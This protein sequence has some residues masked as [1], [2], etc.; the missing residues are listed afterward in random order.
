MLTNPPLFEVSY[1][2]IN[3]VGHFLV[4]YGLSGVMVV[5]IPRKWGKYSYFEGGKE[6]IFCRS[7]NIAEIFFVSNSK[8]NVSSV[9][10]HPGSESDCH[11]TILSSDNCLR[12]YDVTNP[13]IPFQVIALSCVE[14]SFYLTSNS[15]T[16]FSSCLGETAV[17]FDFGPPITTAE[18]N[19]EIKD[20]ELDIIWPIFILK[21]NGDVYVVHS[22]L[23]K[24]SQSK[25]KGPLTM[26]PSAIDNYGIDNCSLMCLQVMPPVLVI[27]TSYGTLY[28][29]IVINY[30][31]KENLSE[32]NEETEYHPILYVYEKVELELTLT[33]ADEKD[34][35]EFCPIHL[36]KDFSS[37]VRYYCTHIAGIHGIALP[38]IQK[39]EQFAEVD[40]AENFLPQLEHQESI[41]EHVICSQPLSTT[42]PAPILG[43]GLTISPVRTVLISLL[44]SWEFICL[45]LFLDQQFYHLN[46]LSSFQPKN[47]LSQKQIKANSF[48]HYMNNILRHSVTTPLL[49]SNLISDDSQPSPQEWLQ[50]LNNVTQRLREEYIEKLDT[51]IIQARK[52]IEVLKELKKQQ[53]KD[54]DDCMNI[55][56]HLSSK[57]EAL[58]EKYEDA[59]NVQQKLVQRIEKVLQKL[60]YSL[61]VLSDA[62]IEMKQDLKTLDDKLKKLKLSF[63]QIQ[64]KFQNQKKHLLEN[65]ILFSNIAYSAED[66]NNNQ[67]SIIKDILKEE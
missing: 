51:A 9:V 38:L 14:P 16:S 41:V 32:S 55:K 35:T 6:I 26:Y 58:A 67:L 27:S 10:W 1:V 3:K 18:R 54:I 46:Y 61:P 48:M 62:E 5:E 31:E 22:N 11:L 40:D 42:A 4:L 19:S 12:I 28:H 24:R 52:R 65:K 64:L 33:P 53:T 7:W 59:Y 45:P 13:Q 44:S 36:Y 15:R 20:H 2:L 47:G 29:C 57:E 43:F 60:Q 17:S 63:E 21:G 66:L 39:L 56:E 34:D 25:V 23:K 50:L 8:V 37:N 30:L 49:K